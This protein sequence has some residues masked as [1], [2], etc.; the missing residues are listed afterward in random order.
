MVSGPWVSAELSEH[1]W[2]HT[3]PAVPSTVCL[4]CLR[5]SWP[6][7]AENSPMDTQ[8]TLVQLWNGKLTP[9][10]SVPK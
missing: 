8:P 5:S 1:Q 4:C 7:A 9:S 3:V 6:V 2:Q 10:S